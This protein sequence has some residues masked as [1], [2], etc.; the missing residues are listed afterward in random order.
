LLVVSIV[1]FALGR[2]APSDYVDIA[3]GT[4]RRNPEA[5]ER[6]KEERGLKDPVYEQYVRYMG[7]FVRGDFG[8]SVRYRGQDIEDV[9]LPKLWITLQ[10]NLV[11][12]ILTFA[13]GLPIGILAAVNRGSWLDPLSIGAFLVFASVPVIVMVPLAQLIFVIWLGWLP[14]GGWES[15][16]VLGINLG[17]LHTEA[18]LPVMV[19]TL[20]G[21]AGLARYMRAQVVDVLAQDYIRTARAKGLRENI[22]VLRHVVRNAL[23]PIATLLGFELAALVS[24]S[25]IVETLLGIPGIGQFAFESVTS[26]DYD[27]IMA[28]VLLGSAVFMIAMLVVDISYGFIDPRIRLTD[29][30]S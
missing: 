17:I 20:P 8:Q 13:I 2:F 19:L 9:I 6:I 24:G 14:T 5:I 26:R 10:I 21:V 12:L 23:L 30:R 28:V 15:R 25:I 18:I 7:K 11:V 29:Q 3:V 1:T 16:D 22:V 27:S 4:G